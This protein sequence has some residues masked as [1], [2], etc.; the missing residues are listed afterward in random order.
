MT[1]KKIGPNAYEIQFAD[2]LLIL[3]SYGEPVAARS[4]AGAHGAAVKTDKY[5]SRTTSGH[6]KKWLDGAPCAVL[7]HVE[8]QR[9]AAA[10]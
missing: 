3:F 4:H 9:M 8:M 10:R 5:F 1:T 6:I 2:G 7:P